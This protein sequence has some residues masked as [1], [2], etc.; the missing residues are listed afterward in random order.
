M[1]EKTQDPVADEVGRGLVSGEEQ[2]DRGRDELFLARRIVLLVRGDE[3]RDEIVPRACTALSDQ[4]TE[5]VAAIGRLTILKDDLQQA[6][7][8]VNGGNTL[9]DTVRACGKL[10]DF[11]DDINDATGLAITPGPPYSYFIPR[12]MRIETV[13]GC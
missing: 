8:Y 7:N 4:I 10:R 13:M 12:A 1:A 3:R 2:Q 5:V 6:L 9:T 11:I